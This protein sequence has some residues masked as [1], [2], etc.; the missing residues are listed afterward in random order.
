MAK[1]FYE[2][3]EQLN[4]LVDEIRWGKIADVLVSHMTVK[5]VKEL[6]QPAESQP[7]ENNA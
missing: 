5:E 4:R 2:N 3:R 6:S 1:I 7:Q